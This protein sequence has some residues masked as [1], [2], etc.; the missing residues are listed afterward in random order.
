MAKYSLDDMYRDALRT[1]YFK[2]DSDGAQKKLQKI[3]D[4]LAS[5]V[6]EESPLMFRVPCRIALNEGN[7]THAKAHAEAGLLF[8]TDDPDIIL[9]LAACEIELGQNSQATK[10]VDEALKVIGTNDD[11]LR[12]IA[13][14]IR[15][16]IWGK[17]RNFELQLDEYRNALKYYERFPLA[18]ELMGHAFL[19][20]GQYGMARDSFKHA[21]SYGI[22]MPWSQLGLGIATKNLGDMRSAIT[23]FYRVIETSSDDKILF[24]AYR[25]LAS[26]YYRKREL[27]EARGFYANALEFYKRDIATLCDLA[28]VCIESGDFH[29]ASDFLNMAIKQAMASTPKSREIATK[30][31]AQLKSHQT[32]LESRAFHASRKISDTPEI[33]GLAYLYIGIVFESQEKYADS[34]LVYDRAIEKFT[35]IGFSALEQECR[36][37]ISELP[38]GTGPTTDQQSS[39]PNPKKTVAQKRQYVNFSRYRRFSYRR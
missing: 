20:M 32:T 14:L 1:A 2:N 7:I 29:D 30:G 10:L 27:E 25:N 16:D 4:A 5:G 3:N 33:L 26:C 12:A 31:I 18:H 37:R 38:A 19:E 17:D 23:E 9:I 22:A 34:K 13:C 35:A 6:I 24:R 28:V 11:E 15:G 21:L 36:R 39:E 8:Y